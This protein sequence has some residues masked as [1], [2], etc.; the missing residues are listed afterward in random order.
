[1]A[2]LSS[3]QMHIRK[4]QKFIEYNQFDTY[5][6]DGGVMLIREYISSDCEKIAELFYQTVHTVKAKD[7]AQE[8]LQVWATGHIDLSSW[9]KSFLE[10]NTRVAVKNDIIVGFGDIDKTG[11]LDRLYVH[12]DYQRQGVATALCNELESGFDKITTHASITAK[13][14][15][16]HRGYKVVMEQQ[17]VRNGI[18]LTNYVMEK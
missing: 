14:F 17:V 18:S 11:Y 1:M 3:K 16:L 15:F 5:K 10:H 9:N 13:P 12:K 7:Y 6:F 4:Q 2:I 8:Q